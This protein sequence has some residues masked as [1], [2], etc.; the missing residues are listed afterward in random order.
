MQ[1]SSVCSSTG[2][3]AT[4]CR[5]PTSYPCSLHSAQLPARTPVNAQLCLPK[6]MVTFNQN[7]ENNL[8]VNVASN[9][10]AQLYQMF[11]VY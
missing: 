1:V 5:L 2:L 8:K 7:A 3:V 10:V 6:A 9:N 4:R 11:N